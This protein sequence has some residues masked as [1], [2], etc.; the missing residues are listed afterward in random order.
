[1]TPR[2]GAGGGDTRA[3]AVPGTASTATAAEATARIRKRREG[4][5][6]CLRILA[7]RSRKLSAPSASIRRS[8][9][10]AA[11]EVPR[12]TVRPRRR[13]APRAARAALPGGAGADGGGAPSRPQPRRQRDRRGESP[14][15][16]RPS[17]P[18]P[19]DDCAVRIRTLGDVLLDVVVRLEE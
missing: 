11:R 19:W 1:M 15:L 16:S 9:P 13:R 8:L 18:P 10:I 14:T 6:K 3:E 12:S 7:D 17:C 5:S 4:P 2:N